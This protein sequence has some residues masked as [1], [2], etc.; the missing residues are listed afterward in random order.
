MSR[1]YRISIHTEL[2]KRMT[3]GGGTEN[4]LKI[5]TG[6]RL[7]FLG[8]G[9]NPALAQSL[10]D[11]TDQVVFL[12]NESFVQA[13]P[14][15]WHA[16]VPLSW[17]RI[18]PSELSSALDNADSV[19][20]YRPNLK[21]FPSYWSPVWAEARLKKSASDLPAERNNEIW[22]PYR[23]HEL[24]GPELTHAFASRSFKVIRLP[25][26]IPQDPMI[27]RNLKN[28]RPRMY[29]SVNF[30][31]LDPHGS[32]ASL[33]QAAGIP[34]SVWCVDNPFHL[35]SGMK[36]PFWQELNL[37]VTDPWFL[38][39]LRK[40]GA[41]RVFHLPLA[42]SPEFF[43]PRK[44]KEW[45]AL[46]TLFCFVGRSQFRKKSSFFAGINL[47]PDALHTAE[48]MLLKGERSDFAWWTRQCPARFWPGN[49]VRKPGFGAEQSGSFWRRA[50]LEQLARTGKLCIFGDSDWK[51]LLN[52]TFILHNEVDYYTALPRI[53]EHALVTINL[54]SLLLPHGLTQRHFDVWAAGGFLL[55]DN[56]PGL[57]LF[58]KELTHEIRFRTPDEAGKLAVRFQ[59]DEAA[60]EQLSSAWREHILAEHTYSHRIDEILNTV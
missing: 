60:R 42:A 11:Q 38:D 7:L 31:G 36:S 44:E 14:S 1:P 57:G 20:F 27:L 28:S 29:L 49:K 35:L 55:S 18:S 3:L 47:D 19:F 48:T 45:E 12:E 39:P 9:H 5:G 50:V 25:R 41:K 56:T 6:K 37:F 33:L 23:Q 17:T 10:T 40:H 15:S 54:T 43:H 34:V 58:P 16:A 59:K 21:T 51:D 32:T 2:G 53:Y 46:H 24:L 4:F 52:G 13:M 8:L 30:H 22:M 26:N